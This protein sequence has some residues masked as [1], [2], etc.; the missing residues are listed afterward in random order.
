MFML[1]TL[2]LIE[3]VCIIALIEIVIVIAIVSPLH[4]PAEIHTLAMVE[5]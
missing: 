1:F 3:I 2:V 5:D 4:C